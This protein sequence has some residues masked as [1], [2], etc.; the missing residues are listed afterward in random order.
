MAT[1]ISLIRMTS[2]GAQTVRETPKRVEMFR[3]VMKGMGAELKSWHLT[4]GQYDVVTMFEAPNDEVVAKLALAL[5]S[6]GNAK[7]ETMRAFTLEDFSKIVAGL[8]APPK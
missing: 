6:M 8:P 1:Y 2:Q 7:T 3:E 5:A 4:F